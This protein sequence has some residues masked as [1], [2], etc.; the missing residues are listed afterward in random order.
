MNTEPHVFVMYETTFFEGPKRVTRPIKAGPRPASIAQRTLVIPGSDLRFNLAT[1]K[2]A[3]KRPGYLFS[4]YE[5]RL[6][7]VAD[8]EWRLIFVREGDRM[9][10]VA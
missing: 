10:K 5:P 2:Q 7:W 3:S 1:G 8:A 9:R 6:M 4:P